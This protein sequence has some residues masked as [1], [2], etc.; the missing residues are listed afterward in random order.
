MQ[1]NDFKKNL[2]GL[3]R[4]Q[5]TKMIK[6]ITAKENRWAVMTADSEWYSTFNP[7]IGRAIE[8]I[9]EGNLAVIDYL[10]NAKGFK[11]INEIRELTPAEQD[12]I[13]GMK[14]EEK[15][16]EGMKDVPYVPNA[17]DWS[18]AR[19]AAGKALGMLYAGKDVSVETL[20]EAIE[21]LT[22]YYITG[23]K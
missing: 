12:E 3:F 8:T 17:K 5:V 21:M 18:I 23:K 1:W 2:G 19:Q 9:G 10:E 11:N 22:S 4:M 15:E 6:R 13:D 7:D 14:Q 20:I 16:K